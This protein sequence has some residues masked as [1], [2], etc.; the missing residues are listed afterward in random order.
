MKKLIVIIIL[1]IVPSI[2]PQNSIFDST[3]SAGIKQIYD[4]KFPEAEKTFRGLIADYPGKPQGRFFLA[5]VDWWK[6]LLDPDNESYDDVFYQKL[7]DVIFQC[8]QI[9]KKTPNDVNALFF[10]G[11]AIGF[12][13]RLR[14]F[15][16]SWLKAA[17]DG[18]D[19]L[20]IVEHAAK[21]DPKNIDV[22]LGFGIYNYYAAVI[23]EQYPL[24]KPLMIFFPPGNKQKGIDELTNVAL[25]GKYAKYEARYFLMTLYFY[26]ENNPFKADYFANM[27]TKDFPDNPL[28]ERWSGRIAAKRGDY[29]NASKIFSDVLEK[30]DKNYTGYNYPSVRRESTYYIAYQYK[31]LSQLDSAIVYF[32]ECAN[33]SKQIDLKE[34]SG[35]LS[36]SYLYLGMIYD[37]Q[38]KREKAIEYYK[39]TLHLKDYNNS[40]ALAENYLKSPYKN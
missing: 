20:P 3:V 14:A 13:G 30:A 37:L 31:N 18:R 11:G 26:F 33:L 39:K 8:D 36:N 12:R 25:N 9:L 1:L 22:Q 21:L 35:F 28:F 16:E 7:E 29:Y 38:S 2:L 27:L 15:R 19:A 34:T 5:M 32:K 4:I 10:K 6:I 23:P 24:M 40:R 17:D